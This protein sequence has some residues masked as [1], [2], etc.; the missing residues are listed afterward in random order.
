MPGD[1]FS[2][3]ELDSP[4][5]AIALTKERSTSRLCRVRVISSPQTRLKRCE[6]DMPKGGG[7]SLDRRDSPRTSICADA[8]LRRAGQNNY[9]VHAYD[10]SRLGCRVE[11]VERPTIDECVW[12]KFEGIE[13][14]EARVRWTEHFTAGL[15]FAHAIH[16]AVFSLLLTRIRR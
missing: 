12:I 11:F 4:C 8:T 14:I 13:T 15:Q 2:I 7:G 9:R 5:C 3:P 1:R 16:P 10:I 6:A